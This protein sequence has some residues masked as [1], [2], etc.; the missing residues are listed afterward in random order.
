MAFQI[1]KNIA[2]NTVA[3]TPPS[4]GDGVTG[5]VYGDAEYLFRIKEFFKNKLGAT[6]TCTSSRVSGTGDTANGVSASDLWADQYTLAYGE[7]YVGL[8]MPTVRGI[9]RR[10]LIQRA[11]A[12]VGYA[13]RVKVNYTADYGATGTPTVPPVVAGEVYIVGDSAPTYQIGGPASGS[14]I[15]QSVGY[16][17][18]PHCG[19]CWSYPVGGGVYGSAGHFFG[20]DATLDGTYEAGTDDGLFL[21]KGGVLPIPSDMTQDVLSLGALASAR[22]RLGIAGT[23]FAGAKMIVPN[24]LAGTYP[25][26][27]RS[28]KKPVFPVDYFRTTAPSDY[29]GQSR[30]FKVF[31]PVAGSTP[32]TLNLA[33][34][35]DHI[36]IDQLAVPWDGTEPL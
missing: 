27:P 23:L 15:F 2:I 17:D 30:L 3:V 33:G 28:G 9:T 36:T 26:N 35:K 13:L 16:D 7:S 10:L 34:T 18:S 31:G 32:R 4:Y 1:T 8:R 5:L 11:G 14:Y 25:A 22:A 24:D 20:L 29:F 19:L 21:F 12:S 6:V